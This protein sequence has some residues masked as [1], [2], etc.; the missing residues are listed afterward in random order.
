MNAV[1]HGT[2]EQL[3]RYVLGQLPE[4][5]IVPL[6]EHLLLC[7]VCREKL[8]EA[9]VLRPPCAKRCAIRDLRRNRVLSGQPG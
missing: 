1:K 8:D 2:E 6:E 4:S 5:E 9:G 7:E 3:E